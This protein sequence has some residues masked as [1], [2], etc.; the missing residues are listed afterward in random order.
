MEGGLRAK[1]VSLLRRL[2]EHHRNLGEALKTVQGPPAPHSVL[3]PQSLN[4]LDGCAS[5]GVLGTPCWTFTVQ[6]SDPIERCLNRNEVPVTN[7]DA[8]PEPRR[9]VLRATQPYFKPQ[10]SSNSGAESALMEEWAFRPDST[11]VRDFG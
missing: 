8:C 4:T 9:S 3:R 6:R 7:L 10:V 5:T 1:T 2:A 11:T